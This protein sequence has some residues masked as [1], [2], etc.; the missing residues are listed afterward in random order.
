M[1]A[2]RARTWDRCQPR[3]HGYVSKW[4]RARSVWKARLWRAW[5]LRAITVRRPGIIAEK[6]TPAVEAGAERSGLKMHYQQVGPPW[7]AAMNHGI[8]GGPI[9]PRFGAT[10]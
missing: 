4:P 9:P 7:G 6:S 5:V 2:W 3:E 10:W 1:E 8:G